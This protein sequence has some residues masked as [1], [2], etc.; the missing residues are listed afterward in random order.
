MSG[1]NA[2]ATSDIA[3]NAI[4]ETV[5]HAKDNPKKASAS[6]RSAVVST[7]VGAHGGEAEILLKTSYVLRETLQ[8]D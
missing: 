6:H 1:F 3:Y 5:A 8:K 7:K 4:V 2:S